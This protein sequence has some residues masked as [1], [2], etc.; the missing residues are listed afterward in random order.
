M[1]PALS[2]PGVKVLIADTLR[3]FVGQG[4]RLSWAD[5]ADATGDAE[6]KLRAYVE[7]DGAMMPGDVLLRVFAALPPAAFARIARAIGFAASPL[8]MDDAATVRRGLAEAARLVA[9]GTEFLE[10]GK[11]SPSERAALAGR[12][13]T[14]LPMLQFIAG[15]GSA[16]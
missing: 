13:A 8:E 2:A 15:N 12:A 9:D 10:D 4:K 7:E 3:L 14:L 16:R 11:L 1:M 6:R 5:L